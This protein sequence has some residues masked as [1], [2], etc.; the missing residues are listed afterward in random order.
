MKYTN[1]ALAALI[2]LLVILPVLPIGGDS[3]S[4]VPIPGRGRAE[5]DPPVNGT[6]WDI[7][8]DYTITG[9]TRAFAGHITVFT[10]V[11]LYIRNMGRLVVPHNDTGHWVLFVKAGG[12]V[13]V[14][15]GSELDVDYYI[16]ESGTGL[17][18]LNSSI[19]KANGVFN[20]TSSVTFTDSTLT[21]TAPSGRDPSQLGEPAK[22]H[23]DSG[24]GGNIQRSTLSV[25]GGNGQKGADGDGTEGGAGG[26]VSVIVTSKDFS[27]MKLTA[28]AGNGG[29]GG[30]PGRTTLDA[31]KGGRGG[32]L[33]IKVVG[34]SFSD[35]AI[36]ASS[37]NGGDGLD[38]TSP[39]GMDAGHGGEGGVAGT[40]DFRWT[41]KGITVSQ[42][43]R[44]DIASG[45]GGKGGKGGLAQS[46]QK[47]GGNGGR[48]GNGGNIV[49]NITSNGTL[50]MTDSSI[51]I[52][53]G[54]GPTGGVYGPAN[55][56]GK[57]G[58]AGDGGDGGSCALQM[59]QNDAFTASNSTVWAEAGDGGAGGL[60]S[61]GGKG[62][63]G[64]SSLFNLSLE[65]LLS[66]NTVSVRS[67]TLA[68]RGGAGGIGGKGLSEG[69]SQGQP[70]DGGKG[71]GAKLFVYA[72][73]TVEFTG[74]RLLCDE[75]PYGTAD[76]PAKPGNPGV[77]EL[78]MYTSKVSL[79]STIYSQTMGW[80]D[81]NDLWTL[82]SSP[83]VRT[84][85][86]IRPPHFLPRAEAGVAEEYWIL[87][88]RVQ[89]I[90]GNAITDGTVTVEVYKGETLA[91]AK[92]AD[93][94]GLAP[95]RLLGS[96]Y[97]VDP[98][99]DVF[100][101]VYTVKATKDS[102][103]FAY[104]VSA[105]MVEDKFLT[106]TIIT[107]PH[108]PLCNVTAPDAKL[109]PII[110]ASQ[111]TRSD[112]RTEIFII[113]GNAQDNPL[114]AMPVISKIEVRIGEDGP[115]VPA[116]FEMA[117]QN[118]YKWNLTWDI[119]NWSV[120]KLS[121][122]PSG[123]IHAPIYARSYNDMSWSDDPAFEG[124]TTVSNITVRLLK[125]PPPLPQVQITKPVRSP[126]GGVINFTKVDFERQIQF[127]G[128]VLSSSGT[129]IIKW[130]WCF[131]TAR[132]YRPEFSSPV[133][134]A[135]NATYSR[136]KNDE[137][138]DV[139][140]KVF[141]NES[142]RR[143]EL[144][145][146]GVSYDEFKYEFDTNDGSTVVKL[147]VYVNPIVT[148][149]VDPYAEFLKRYWHVLTLGI[150]AMVMMVGTIQTFRV[151]QRS[152]AE[153]KAKEE[154]ES[155]RID[156]SEMKCARCNEPI[157]D[158]SVGCLQC[159][160]QDALGQIQQRLLDIKGSGV[161]ITDAE[162]ILEIG[163]DAFDAK[164]YTE[165]Y[166]KAQEAKAKASEIEE[167]Y[168]K[169]SKVISGWETRI[170]AM[171][172]DRPEADMSDAETKVYHSRLALGR[173]DHDEAIKNLDGLEGVL[174]KADKVGV[175]KAAQE[176]L[177]STRRM[178]A[179]IQ[180][181][182]VMLDPKISPAISE[183][184]TALERG[185]FDLV[186]S[187]CKEAET[188]VKETNRNFMRASEH[189]RHSESRVLNAKGMG[190]SVGGTEDWLAQAK[191]A[192]AGGNYTTVIELTGRVLGFF[193]VAVKPAGAEKRVDWK[194]EVAVMEGREGKAATA[195][196]AIVAPA[197]PAPVL[198]VEPSP[199][200]KEAAERLIRD[201]HDAVAR[202][203]EAAADVSDGEGLLEKA[204]D[205][206][207]ARRY[208]EAQDLA[209]S[210][211]FLLAELAAAAPKPRP[212]G[213]PA[214]APRPAAAPTVPARPAAISGAAAELK[215]QIGKADNL[216][217][218]LAAAGGDISGPEDKLKRAKAAR[219][220]GSPAV[221]MQYARESIEETE[222]LMKEYLDA[223]NSMEAVQKDLAAARSRGLDVSDAEFQLKQARAA[224]AGGAFVRAADTAKLVD[225][226]LKDLEPG[227]APK[228]PAVT[229][230]AA[231]KAP[232][233]KCPGCGRD[234][235][236]HWKT[237][238]FCGASISGEKPAAEAPKPAAAAAPAVPGAPRP[239]VI[240]PAPEA[241]KAPVI[242][243]AP[244]APRPPV[245]APAPAPVAAKPP[246]QIGEAPAKAGSC[247]K[248]G[249][250]L[251]PHWKVCPSCG[252]DVLAAPAAAPA[253][254]KQARCPACG[255]KV[256]P[257][258]TSCPICNT[259]LVP[260][261]GV[262][263]EAPKKVL[264]V[265]KKPVI[266]GEPKDQ[267][268]AEPAEKTPVLKVEKKPVIITK[269]EGKK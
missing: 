203:R 212:G 147:R 228:P 243:P 89:D 119:Y 265:A 262:K 95:F 181:R 30:I 33:D 254:P 201:A 219:D 120:A 94:F 127:D 53:A 34:N 15:D 56:G 57:D 252:S 184:E 236:P 237:C 111:Y 168:Q 47:A 159:K 50:S 13:E 199:E 37:G 194:R 241:P 182:G 20:A 38:G 213:A 87:T 114:N 39:T 79:R 64:G 62:G 42:G 234:A 69:V 9:S 81:Q 103:E 161:N 136:D 263:P 88:V 172:V 238:P 171:K 192:M 207:K 98:G 122:F 162:S 140:L 155:L 170:A 167:K 130:E 226:M 23:L 48:G 173:G 17:T 46:S 244:P 19:V 158:P 1:A 85:P 82:E 196:P 117:T 264:K 99:S 210:A 67:G 84:N 180:K 249:A 91:S 253:A 250:A 128:A 152:I 66:E 197:A 217:V 269:D 40:V 214:P 259:A 65:T 43:S 145:R 121:L 134:P 211:K 190:Q 257:S 21:V 72:D 49:A 227:G 28:I 239:P 135:T 102:G 14:T 150:I 68:S 24:T 44:I 3:A 186:T 222:G 18:V 41:G 268:P 245:I 148:K 164:S 229:A 261:K 144:Y 174:A 235:K 110:D 183:A 143:V 178:L 142:A 115:W 225:Q 256:E 63:V 77:G 189:L 4:G 105:Q 36:T 25:S 258:W 16:A 58:A 76:A 169:T 126:T 223:R 71:G 202:A 10:G 74:S 146:A 248:C 205:A 31:G 166:E 198:E 52:Q 124:K 54:Y 137:Y 7:V 109:T 100:G 133:S 113:E 218:E 104:P 209:K 129:K 246:A 247:P 163:V 149:Q 12:N 90:L 267:P 123:I 80:V 157:A 11:N 125:I 61:T 204:R 118:F 45:H 251:K 35:S 187:R 5:G 224:M 208:D 86:P 55:L 156:V 32:S 255:S 231:P 51:N 177:E 132:G 60:G 8:R 153:R 93:M 232:S 141:D 29:K 112:G 92:K 179:N 83:L 97:T 6:Q 185:T 195:K 221:A 78:Y 216:L 240:A 176:L 116:N 101:I 230:E 22:L 165:A 188:L 106:L 242:A 215:A 151:R 75:G 139:W 154:R 233:V 191:T 266:A 70:G 175:R 131:D 2:S 160:A 27:G 260:D 220:G 107:K 26:S 206:Y 200:L 108:A 138:I 193:G 96:R 59:A 73:R